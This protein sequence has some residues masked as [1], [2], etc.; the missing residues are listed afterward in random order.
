MNDILIVNG[1]VIDGTGA[2]AYPADIRIRNGIIVEIGQ[3]LSPA[4]ERVFDAG[5]CYVAPGFIESHTHFDGTMWWQNDLDPLPGNGATTIILGN[6]GFTCAPVSDD[7][8]ARLEMLKIFSFFE[9]IPMEPFRDK[10]KWDWRTWSEYKKSLTSSVRLPANYA[11]YCGH[12]A[13]RLAVMGLDAWDRKAT[14]EEISRMAALLDD[15]LAAGALGLS[16]NLLDYDGQNRPI[17]SLS[18]DDDEFTA[19]IDVLARYPARTLQIIVDIFVRMTAP[20]SVERIARLCEGKE[21]RVQW[22]G[23]P[24]LQFQ[25]QMGIQSKMKEIHQRLCREGRDFW[26]GHAHRPPSAVVSINHSIAFAQSKCFVW[27]EVV[28]AETEDAKLALLQDPEWRARARVDLEQNAIK[29]SALSDGEKLFF[30]NSENGVGPVN[31][32]AGDFAR[33]LG[34]SF[35]DAMAEWF[36]RNGVNSTVHLAPWP[37][38]DETLIELFNDP[39]AVGNISD[40]GAH[41]QMLCGG[42]ENMLLFTKY[43]KELGAISLEQ[44]VHVL[45][46]KLAQHFYLSDRGEIKVGKKGDIVVFDFDEIGYRPLRKIYDVPDNHVEGGKTWRWTR[47]AAPMRLTLVNGI[48]TFEQ[49]SF[50]GALPGEML[51]PALA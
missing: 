32:T 44:A 40:A 1:S 47:D 17:P 48:P 12:V 9:D 36:V 35:S 5:G 28:L 2:P 21:V 4:G 20:A 6:C 8:A 15:A 24:I 26:T 13:L 51:T 31:C 39:K 45:T 16:S 42:G 37:V 11:A 22:A 7:E 46:G 49:G 3:K 18:A 41:G 25:K 27:H 29:Q 34:V 33:E 43:V 38:D 19:L 23:L 10:V 30:Y 14:P 50:T